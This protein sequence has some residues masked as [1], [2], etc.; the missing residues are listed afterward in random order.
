MT[1]A[2][3]EGFTTGSAAT[4]ASLAALERLLLGTCPKEVLTPLPPF[5]TLSNKITPRAWKVIPIWA[6]S[7]TKNTVEA[8]TSVRKD[9]GDD[10]DATHG[11][12]ISAHV[13]LVRESLSHIHIQGG[14][15]IG[16]ITKPGLPLPVGEWAINPVPRSQI[17]FA[18][19]HFWHT[20]SDLPMPSLS[21]TLSVADGERIA[22][23]TLNPRLGILGGIS[24]LGTQG[25]VLPYSNHAFMATIREQLDMARAMK[26]S[27]ILLSTG[28]RSERFLEALYPED[29][30]ESFL[31]VGDFAGFSVREAAERSFSDIVFGCFF[32]K[33]VKLANGHLY[34]HAHS[35]SLDLRALGELAQQFNCLCAQEIATLETAA[36]ALSF[37]EKE[38]CGKYVLQAL[39]Q[40][41]KKNLEHF[42]SHSITLHLFHCEGRLLS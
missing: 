41:A 28:R 3:R 4:A 7:H 6:C 36:H 2:L 1:K 25:T 31:S 18:L 37:L 9:G 12:I 39:C 35:Q 33:L 26:V 19:S 34:T 29:P 20:H 15:G 22:K 8:G 40:R 32:G 21:V 16:K 23:K 14:D 38:D 27:R 13:R 5:E 42:S 30:K 17:R 10:P 11:A 24:I